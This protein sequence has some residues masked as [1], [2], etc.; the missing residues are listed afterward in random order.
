MST[1]GVLSRELMEINNSLNKKNSFY[2]VGGMGHAISIANGIAIK[3]KKKRVF[4]F[5][6]DGAALMHLGALVNS[7][8]ANNLVHI[9][10]NNK[11][12]DS[13]GA[14]KTASNKILFYKIADHLGYKKTFS[15]KNKSQITKVLKLASKSNSSIFVELLC[16]PGFRSNLIRPQKK[17]TFYKKE[18]MKYLKK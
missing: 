10:I 13:V 16:R 1:T 6:G 5:D 15:C 2:C 4:C 3:K 7:S 14:Q 11:S 17:M 18:F 9:L 12:H 8:Q